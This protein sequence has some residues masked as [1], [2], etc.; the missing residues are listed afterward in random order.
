MDYMLEDNLIW[1]VTNMFHIIE[2]YFNSLY[3]TQ[4]IL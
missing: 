1:I 3:V 2:I 4:K